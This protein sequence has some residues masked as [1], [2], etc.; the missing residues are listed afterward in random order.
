MEIVPSD[1]NMKVVLITASI[2]FAHKNYFVYAHLGT[3]QV[4]FNV[5]G[6]R[7][8]KGHVTFHLY[9]LFGFM[10]MVISSEI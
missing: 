4:I 9:S 7:S 5:T 2:G 1:R 6:E 3:N 10:K 8:K